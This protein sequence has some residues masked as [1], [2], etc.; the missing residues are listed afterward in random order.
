VSDPV[1][2]HLRADEGI[3]PR[4][5]EYARIPSVSTDPAYADGMAAA[6][7]LLKGRLE[8]AG[9]QRVGEIEAGG[10]PAVVAEWMGAPGAPVYLV[11]GHYDVQPPDPV[12]AWRS[13]P[14]EPQVREGR[15]YGRGVSDDKGPASIALEV[16]S[17]FLKVEGHLP[18]NIRILLE[19][20]EEIGSA[21]LAALCE[22]HRDRLAADAVISADGAR[23]RADLPTVNVGTRGNA[24][25]EI[26]VRTAAKDLHSGRYGGAVPNAITSMARLLATLHDENGRIAV[27]GFYDDVSQ[28]TRDERAA[29]AALPFDEPAWFASVG[30]QP[31][32]EPGFSTL[33]RL[34]LRPTV[35]LNGIWGG[36]TGPGGKTVTPAEAFAKITTRLVPEQSPTRI[37]TLLRDHFERC[38]P[39]EA[40]VRVSVH[41]NGTP[42][43]TVPPDHPLLLSVEDA[44]AAASGARP[45]RVRV[46]GTLP[47]ASI[48]KS[49]L[50][51]DTVT[52]SF[53]TADEDFHA[54]NEF[55]RLSA[56][57]EGLTAWVTLLRQLGRKAGQS[58]RTRPGAADQ[59]VVSAR[60][61]RAGRS[62]AGR[63]RR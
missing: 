36:Y 1:L 31:S 25:F 32:G 15:L 53:S 26:A 41:D 11:Y 29:I 20:E 55:F 50:G 60:R 42:A 35:E 48:F 56:L 33:E 22:R 8:S 5:V 13:P 19:G 9:F 7:A 52:L 27:S 10:H 51:V 54:P 39:L 30:A 34:W 28:P 40:T 38:C 62:T 14:F 61:R 58:R 44:V 2:E 57:P 18:V 47:L 17:A 59:P 49:R 16:L 6:R 45:Y 24:G 3:L 46:G 4:L 63:L 43:Y 21:T 12:A 37:A 23:W